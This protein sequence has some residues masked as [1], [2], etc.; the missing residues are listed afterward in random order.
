MSEEMG[1]ST[2]QAPVSPAWKAAYLNNTTEID[3][4]DKD[5]D[6]D[7][8]SIGSPIQDLSAAHWSALR[9]SGIDED[10]AR[11][12]GYRTV[13]SKRELQELGF[14]GRQLD[15]AEAGDVL[16]F[17]VCSPAGDGYVYQ[18]RPDEPRTDP[19]TGK[20]IKYETPSGAKAPLDVNPLQLRLVL[21]GVTP[22]MVTE[23]VKKGDALVSA[24]RR[25]RKAICTVAMLG[26]WMAQTE[27]ALAGWE[28]I[29]L[30][31]RKVVIAFDS[32]VSTN[33]SV[34]VAAQKTGEFLV[35]RGASVTYAILP[36]GDGGAK[37]GLDDFLASGRN[38]DDLLGLTTEQPPTGST[39]SVHTLGLRI[40]QSTDSAVAVIARDPEVF[41][42]GNILVRVLPGRARSSEPAARS[43]MGIGDLGIDT[44]R[45]R[46]SGA[47]IWLRCSSEDGTPQ[48]VAA[49]SDDVLRACLARGVWPS[50]R[51]LETL[52]QSPVLLPDGTVTTT[53]GFHPSAD[54]LFD[55]VDGPP[56]VSEAPSRDECLTAIAALREPLQDFPFST[57]ADEAAAVAAILTP[58]AAPFV[59]DCQPLIFIDGNVRGSGKTLLVRA[60]SE[61]ATGGGV[62][63]LAPPRGDEEMRKTILALAL[64]GQRTLLIDN[65]ATDFAYPSLDAAVT[66]RR[67]SGRLL[68]ASRYVT[69]PWDVTCFITG[70]NLSLRA[71]TYRRVLVVRLRSPLE[72]PEERA[73]FT[74]S[75]LL[76]W[77][78]ANRVRLQSAAL[79][80][81]RGY[82]AAGLPDQAIAPWGSFEAWS[83]IVRG[84]VVWLG[85][86][87]PL[88]AKDDLRGSLD[89]AEA[90]QRVLIAGWRS[91]DPDRSGL[92][93]REALT[94]INDDPSF[95]ALREAVDDL[96]PSRGDRKEAPATQFGKVL[97]RLRQRVVDG[98]M[99]DKLPGNDRRGVRWVWVEANGTAADLGSPESTSPTSPSSP[100]SPG[101]A[102]SGQWEEF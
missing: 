55:A 53:Q 69:L 74:I 72:S 92:T 82:V 51:R 4:L 20:S 35:G 79:T 58:F 76:Q 44:L 47:A 73:D 29:P 42:R 88:R 43:A 9:A 71:D 30:K 49:P 14:R 6:R 3:Q 91:L 48:R 93:A 84:A 41:Q 68:G 61:I 102:D 101:D 45:E 90:S 94:R 28:K 40:D 59:S 19:K 32:D 52:T 26:V 17:P 33:P 63:A 18:A 81:L 62:G 75:N 87:D 56:T 67:V 10:V 46:L 1:G 89:S 16:V 12:R 97:S 13:L 83:R 24:A 38:I 80:I 66:S 77:V 78:R 86:P 27:A 8:S 23:G 7:V 31:G 99:I 15:V 57:E 37:V 70:N 39:G 22:L 85:L 64:S 54:L 34:A 25:E 65:V 11:A 95:A 100:T 60:I 2:G 21:D 96:C 5:D 98:I 36:P 50:I